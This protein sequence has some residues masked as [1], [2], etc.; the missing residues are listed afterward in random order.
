MK[1]ALTLRKLKTIL[2][3]LKAKVEKRLRSR[4]VYKINCSRCQAYYVGEIDR[5]TR[6]RLRENLH[7]SQLLGIHALL[8][9]VTLKFEVKVKGNRSHFNL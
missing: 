5:H 1:I 9:C 4:V 7:S 2:F 3:Q 6:T 8:C